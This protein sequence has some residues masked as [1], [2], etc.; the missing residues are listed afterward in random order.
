MISIHPSLLPAFKGL[1]THERAIAE[2]AKRHGATVHFVTPELD[3]G[4]I[5]IQD[6]VPVLPGDT[7]D[8]LAA[9]VSRS[10]TASTRKLRNASPARRSKERPPWPSPTFWLSRRP[11]VVVA[12]PIERDGAGRGVLASGPQGAPAY[13]AGVIVG[14][15]TWFSVAATGL[16]AI[17]AAFAPLF[18]AIRY[19]GAAYLLYLA[20]KFWTASARAM[21]TADASPDGAWRSFLTGPRDASRK[22]E[23]DH[24]LPRAAAE[25][26]AAR[27]TDARLASSNSAP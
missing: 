13:A 4:P 3:D 12:F 16:A 27:E 6:S 5:I 15:L 21:E 1:H 9:R 24:V 11:I 20:W 17:A 23:G 18:V 25:R 19:A 26:R 7:P 2:G 10:S 22:S 8:A 14:S